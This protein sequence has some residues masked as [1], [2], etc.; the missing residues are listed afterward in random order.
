MHTD[1]Q[2]RATLNRRERV[3]TLRLT[4]EAELRQSHHKLE[5]ASPRRCGSPLLR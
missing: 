5:N 4:T 3:E 2:I 1:E